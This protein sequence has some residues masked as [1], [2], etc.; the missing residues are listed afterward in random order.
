[1]LKWL[2]IFFYQILLIEIYTNIQKL[3]FIIVFFKITFKKIY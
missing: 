1:M 3:Y 2:E